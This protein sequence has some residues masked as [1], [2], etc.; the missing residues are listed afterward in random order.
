MNGGFGIAHAIR[1]PVPLT[2]QGVT[3]VQ[4]LLA[5]SLAFSCLASATEQAVHWSD[6]NQLIT[7][8]EVVVRLQDGKRVKGRTAAV[9][10]D[11][12]V[13]GTSTGPRSI[14]RSSLREVRLPKRA[15]YKWRIIGTA[16]GAG[17]GAA[18]SVPLLRYA[19][20]EGRNTYEGVAAGLIV[21][22]A[23]LGYLSGWSV[24]RSGDTIRILPD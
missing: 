2:I 4:R 13:V 14:A 10:T 7:G 21:G 9:G 18:V 15:G 5:L 11:S 24:D 19:H 12:L 8:K 20:N 6:L 16:I 3:N 1:F 17:A 23:V 22:L